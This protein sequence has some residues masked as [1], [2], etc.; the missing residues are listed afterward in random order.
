V[1]QS[2]DALHF[3]S[4]HLFK[5]VIQDSTWVDHLPAQVLVVHMPDFVLNAYGWT[6]TSARVALLI[7][8]GFPT[9]G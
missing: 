7:K 6:S 8:V 5:R 2:S 4:V 9:F 1:R 3:G